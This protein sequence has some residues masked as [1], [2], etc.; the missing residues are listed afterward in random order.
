MIVKWKKQLPDSSSKMFVSGKGLAPDR[1]P[2][3]KVLQS[4]IGEIV[5]SLRGCGAAGIREKCISTGMNRWMT[6]R[7]GYA[8]S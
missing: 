8:V 5:C 6:L 1:E 7:K 2:E 4:K 3:I